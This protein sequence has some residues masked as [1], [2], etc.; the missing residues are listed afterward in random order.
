MSLWRSS[1]GCWACSQRWT[2]VALMA[3]YT[4]LIVRAVS[5]QDDTSCACFGARQ[6][7]TPVTV[8]RNVWLTALAIGT[9]AVSVGRS[10]ARRCARRRV[11]TRSRI[12]ADQPS[13]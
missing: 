8:A 3:A 10:A 13:R 6:R 2:A 7:V 5:R 4:W 1:V 11:A 9:A 12:G